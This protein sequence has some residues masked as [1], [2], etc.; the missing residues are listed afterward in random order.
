MNP[1][2]ESIPLKI[3]SEKVSAAR[4]FDGEIGS[5]SISHMW[6]FFG[7]LTREMDFDAAEDTSLRVPVVR[8]L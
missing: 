1:G 8:T 3:D 2:F 6:N 7:G 5:H 4:V